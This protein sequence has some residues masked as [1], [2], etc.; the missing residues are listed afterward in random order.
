MKEKTV[1]SGDFDKVRRGIFR[2]FDKEI[3]GI[4]RGFSGELIKD[5]GFDKS[6]QEGNELKKKR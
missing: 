5:R 2:G 3:P 1:C 4:F 6:R